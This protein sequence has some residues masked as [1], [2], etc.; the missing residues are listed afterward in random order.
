ML[1]NVGV[2]SPPPHH[3]HPPHY[4]AIHPT[5]YELP[6]I[7]CFPPSGNNKKPLIFPIEPHKLYKICLEMQYDCQHD[8]KTI[9]VLALWTTELLFRHPDHIFLFY[10][11]HVPVKKTPKMRFIKKEV[12]LLVI[13]Q[14]CCCRC[15]SCLRTL[16]I[17][18]CYWYINRRPGEL[19]YYNNIYGKRLEL[20][21][22]G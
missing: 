21:P 13:L 8:D 3:H 4:L 6:V 19:N 11:E 12:H 9:H 2:L 15:C 16:C 22:C 20:F 5:N 14:Y 18:Y 1:I 10:K 7:L 17:V